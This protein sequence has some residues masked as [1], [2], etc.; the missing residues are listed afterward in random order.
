MARTIRLMVSVLLLKEGETWVAQCLEHDVA[1]QG[2]SIDEALDNFGAVFAGHVTLD[3]KEGR[4]P[5]ADVPQAP[6]LYW[7]HYKKGQRLDKTL[8]IR[9]PERTTTTGQLLSAA[10]PAWMISAMAQELRVI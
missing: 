7:E 10:P 3:V 4:E 1:A 9:I 6:S 8:P 5:L 2:D